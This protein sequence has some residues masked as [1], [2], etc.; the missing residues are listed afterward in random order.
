[1]ESLALIVRYSCLGLQVAIRY[2]NSIAISSRSY[3]LRIALD[4]MD[5]LQKLFSLRIV[6][7]LVRTI[8]TIYH[9]SIKFYSL[10]YH[11]YNI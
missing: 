3:I 8:T 11:I 1:M 9:K 5:H 6:K 2:K 10:K 7:Q 4:R